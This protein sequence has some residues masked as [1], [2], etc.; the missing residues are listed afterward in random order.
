MKTGW[1]ITIVSVILAAL[2][3]GAIWI[4]IARA[5]DADDADNDNP[6]GASHVSNQSG[7]I[8]LKFDQRSQQLNGISVAE[9]QAT[10]QRTTTQ[11]TG[12][13]LQLQPILDIKTSY[14]T[15]QTDL[16]KAQASARASQA[17]YNR[18][19]K[20]NQ[21]GEN[22]STKSVEAAR[23]SA[24][25]DAAS[26]RN[27]ERTLETLRESTQLHWGT[28][29]TAL[30]LNDSP[31]FS[32]F[33]EQ[34][35]Y[36]IQVAPTGAVSW[37]KPPTDAV[38]QLADGSHLEARLLS[39]L[40]AVDPRLQTPTFLYSVTAHP[41]ILPGSNLPVFLPGGPTRSGVIVPASA[42][43]W[44]QGRAWCYVEKLPGVFSRTAVD[45]SAPTAEGWFV[46][47]GLSPGTQVVRE[48]AQTLLSEEFRSQIKADED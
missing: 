38:V 18:L 48:G 5:S 1:R 34:R 42:I 10:Q 8:E 14:N 40:P 21:D 20:L 26:L 47:P 2:A 27:A 31:R 4:H 9:L 19:L 39:A 29:M 22:A 45:T 43:V 15:A 25:G 7:E 28:E 23:A 3:G 17:E 13:V 36:L 6:Q 24:E 35:A 16:T 41:G 12:T 46:S 44:R 37:K 33:L 30:V 32:S 11:A